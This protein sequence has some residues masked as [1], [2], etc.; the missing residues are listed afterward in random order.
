MHN[1]DV[2]SYSFQELYKLFE[3]PDTGIIDIDS[4]KRA[5]QKVLKMHPDKCKL[6][7]EYFLFYKQAFDIIVDFYKDQNRS[8]QDISESNAKYDINS[9]VETSNTNVITEK[10]AKMDSEQFH[11]M[12]H[13]LF[14]ENMEK[15]Q[16]NTNTWFGETD[17]EYSDIHVSNMSEMKTTIHQIKQRQS[18]QAMTSYHGFNDSQSTHSGSQ[19]YDDDSCNSSDYIVCDSYGTLKYDDLRK[20]HKDQTVF[21]VDEA[22]IASKIQHSSVKDLQTMRNSQDLQPLDKSAEFETR[23]SQWKRVMMEKQYESQKKT[24]VF[25]T[26]NK[27]ILSR[28]LQLT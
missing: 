2:H 18:S 27:Q 7:S 15:K 4:M 1:L 16:S 5:K 22:D 20:V 12:F 9:V 14:Q 21:T 28:F 24:N 3:L 13:K 8:T 19:L 6:P 11:E 10:L 26:K 25:E 17:D 23:E